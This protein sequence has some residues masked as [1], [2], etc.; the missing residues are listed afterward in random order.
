MD[1]EDINQVKA[2]EAW[3]RPLVPRLRMTEAKF[4]SPYILQGVDMWKQSLRFCHLTF[5][6]W[7]ILSDSWQS[8]NEMKSFGDAEKTGISL[9]DCLPFWVHNFY[10]WKKNTLHMQHYHPWRLVLGDMTYC[11]LVI[12]SS[13][14]TRFQSS[15]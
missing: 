8:S 5:K 12:L 10:F 4:Y 2:A 11:L 9:N 15:S 3:S 7:F 13:F 14:R 1:I 6:V